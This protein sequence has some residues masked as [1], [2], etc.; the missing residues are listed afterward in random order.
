M[1]GAGVP[2]FIREHYRYKRALQAQEPSALTLS[3][4]P[5][6]VALSGTF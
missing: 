4:G 5:S 2:A 1:G 3:V 6:G